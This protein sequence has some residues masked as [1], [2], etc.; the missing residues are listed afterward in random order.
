MMGIF[1]KKGLTNTKIISIITDYK[2][3][4][5]WLKDEKSIDALI[6]SNDIV[7]NE[8]IEKGINKHKS[9][10]RF[11]IVSDKLYERGGRFMNR[12]FQREKHPYPGHR[13]LPHPARPWNGHRRY[14]KVPAS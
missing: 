1:N 7:K 13:A 9:A 2:S 5:M 6:V 11:L 14:A 10:S 8:L 12:F 4:E 3:H